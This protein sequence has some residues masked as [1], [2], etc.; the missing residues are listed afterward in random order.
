MKL[1]A[2][3]KAVHSFNSILDRLSSEERQELLKEMGN[4]ITYASIETANYQREH[5]K[6]V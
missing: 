6:D 3:R 4:K 2:I 1:E 5:L